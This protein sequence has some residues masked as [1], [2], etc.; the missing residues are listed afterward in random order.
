MSTGYSQTQAQKQGQTLAPQMRQGLKLLAMNLPELRQEL[1]RE[2]SVNPV[3]D[4]VVPTLEKTTV[5]DQESKLAERERPSDYPDDESDYRET[6]YMEGI[7]R[8]K[9][10]SDP[11]A[12]ARREKFFE[13]QTK[14]E[15]LEEHLLGQL[16]V[17]DIEPEDRGL[18]EILIGNLNDDGYFVGSLPDIQMISGEGEPKIR[19]VLAQIGELDPPGCGAI[20]LADCLRPQLDAIA[21]VVVRERV[22]KLLGRL[23]D[24][25]AA[26][27][28]D[29]EA[30]KALRSLNPRPGRIF[31]H[32]RPGEEFVNPE[33][34]AVRC[35]DGWAA[36][37]DARSLP[38]VRI[39]GKY[40]K[41]LDDPEASAETK[42]YVREKIA[43]AKSLVDAVAHRQETVESI[44][45]AIFDAQPGFFEQGL[46]GLKPLTEEQIAK[47]VGVHPTTVSRTVRDKYAATPKGT[48]ELRR[49]FV[50][51][52]TTE[53]GEMVSKTKIL[54]RLRELIDAEDRA[55]PLSDDKLSDLLK[56]EGFPVARRTVAKYRTAL[57]IPGASER[58]LKDSGGSRG[59]SASRTHET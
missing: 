21:D 38:E 24:V 2:M 14:D 49:F 58:R 30:L 56:A 33:V 37:V 23:D 46:K 1:L 9:N 28:D 41:L 31:R 25:A 39:S 6:A 29:A 32:Q 42:A 20:T 54:D 57:S 19:Q 26:K 34:H 16:P 18:A 12:L 47:A 5:S 15:S 22:R 59:V 53:S 48:V 44:A 11:D 45:Q 40:L 43:A 52:V 7:V 10:G 27:V 50:S 13:N 4:D 17:S 3:I 55:H 51:G 36:R 35:S 8:G